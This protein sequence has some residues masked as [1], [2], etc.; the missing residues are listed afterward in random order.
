MKLF[1]FYLGGK[2]KGC[3]L[4]LHDVAFCVG[5]T[6]EACYPSIKA[7]WFGETEGLHMDAYAPLEAVDGFRIQVVPKQAVTIDNES[8]AQ[9]SHKLYFIYLGGYDPRQFT[10]YHPCGFFVATSVAEA[11]QRAKAEL[12]RSLHL[13]HVDDALEVDACLDVSDYLADHAIVLS[14][15]ASPSP[16]I[17][18][19]CGYN[20]VP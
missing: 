15:D 13:L 1:V 18:Y 14:P 2:A 8:M 20:L 11:K 7:Q 9:P 5:E 4:E 17:S 16:E 6:V 12:G 19:T 3:K 10:E